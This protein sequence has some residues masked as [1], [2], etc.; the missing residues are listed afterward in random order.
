MIERPGAYILMGGDEGVEREAYIGESE[1]VLSRLRTHNSAKGKEFWEDTI[2]LV[3]KD[4]NVTKSHARYVESLL[5]DEAEGNHGWTLP[6][7]QNPSKTAGRLPAPDRVDMDRFVAEAKV[8][9]GVLGCSLFR[10]KR[11]KHED[12]G[13]SR[14]DGDVRPST[15]S[16][17]YKGKEYEARMRPSPDGRFIVEAGSRA[18]KALTRTA[19]TSVKHLRESMIDAGDLYETD[20]SLVFASD[21]IFSSVSAAACVI[22]GGSVNGRAVWRNDAGQTYGEWE[23][24]DSDP[25]QFSTTSAE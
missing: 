19:P 15:V 22:Y 6:N 16:F 11:V 3:S 7:R 20:A 18:R 1:D 4:A 24:A 17:G 9:V 13:A 10:T 14:V 2:V 5:L 25:R 21:Y 23:A 12:P 8:L